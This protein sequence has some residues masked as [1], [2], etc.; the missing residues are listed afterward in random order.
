MRALRRNNANRW[1]AAFGLA[2]AINSK[3]AQ[4]KLLRQDGHLADELAKI[5]NDEI[6]AGSTKDKEPITLRAY[7]CEA[8]GQF[9]VANGLPA[10][11][12]AAST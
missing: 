7:L 1:Q 3:D 9:E 5:L 2:G 4:G 6:E 12:K 10:L 8:L 11:L